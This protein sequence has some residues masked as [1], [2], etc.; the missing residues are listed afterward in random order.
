VNVSGGSFTIDYRSA[1]K[2][3][4]FQTRSGNSDLGPWTYTVGSGDHSVDSYPITGAGLSG[5][6]LSVFGPNG[7]F[8]AFRGSLNGSA[9]VQL[10]VHTSYHKERVA[11]TLFLANHAS[12]ST[13]LDV[14]NAYSGKSTR[15]ELQAGQSTERTFE[16][17]PTFGW[18]DFVV[19]AESDS[20]FR[21]QLAGHVETG[22]ESR[23]DPAI[24]AQ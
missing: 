21:Y 4:V 12:Q 22:E 10:G 17:H 14:M 24:G 18:Y 1:G 7:F 3:A 15:V 20:T 19:T 9:T 23:T 6:D 5:Y 13:H 11:I 16:L 8:R 2:A